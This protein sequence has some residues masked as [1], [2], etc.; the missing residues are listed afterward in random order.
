MSGLYLSS[1]GETK[2]RW[3][4]KIAVLK[5]LFRIKEDKFIL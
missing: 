4:F 1:D 3:N 2:L 5:A